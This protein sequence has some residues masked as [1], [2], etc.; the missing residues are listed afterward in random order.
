VSAVPPTL[1]R[2]VVLAP[3][4]LV[5]EVALVLASPVLLLLAVV[6][7]P[8]FGGWRPVRLVAIA[9]LAAARHAGALLACLG[10]W[11]ASGFGWDAGSE[12][13]Q[14]AHHAV[15]RWFVSGVYRSIERI[16][17]V[18][19]HVVESSDAEEILAAGGR[20]ALVLSRHAG[21]GDTLLVLQHLLCRHGRQPRVVMTDLLRLD[22]LIDVLGRRLNHRFVDPR[23]GDTEVEIAAMTSGLGE[24]EA[25]L[26]FPEGANFS[27][28]Q[29]QKAIDRLER[30]G[31]VEQASW[32]RE[33]RHHSAPRPGGALAAIESA[34]E[35]DVIFVGHI[36]FPAG[37]AELWRL[38][39]HRQ[40]VEVRLWV[41]PAGEIPADH[42]DRIDWLFGW[43]RHLD[44]WVSERHE[45]DA[46]PD[47]SGVRGVGVQ[48]DSAP[49]AD[50]GG[51]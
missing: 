6:L 43:W 25:V 2:R 29:R 35:A 10:L 38:L 28:A 3:A 40:R 51:R 26:I 33:M 17:K 34:P 44:A 24:G 45:D 41:A 21:E 7:S 8:F 31:H 27:E 32:A 1:V 16:A 15:M 11:V 42:L 20:P 4:V 9:L 5:I 19:V 36:G 12:R 14:R 39:P 30:A 48:A 18:D 22:P 49:A 47:D 23:G 13:M 46:G 50:D 37:F